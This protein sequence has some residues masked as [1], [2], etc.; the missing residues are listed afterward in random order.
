MQ[1]GEGNE[2]MVDSCT[3]VS[4]KRISC[5]GQALTRY[6][7]SSIDDAIYYCMICITGRAQ[8][9]RTRGNGTERLL[10]TAR[11]GY[12]TAKRG[13]SSV[14]YPALKAALQLL[15]HRYEYIH[16]AQVPQRVLT[17]SFVVLCTGNSRAESLRYT[18]HL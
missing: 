17:Y 4:N 7:D 5:K 14:Y 12:G 16:F 15:I 2:R 6:V 8:D 10:R 9:A 11:R 13:K 1:L 18:G 3:T